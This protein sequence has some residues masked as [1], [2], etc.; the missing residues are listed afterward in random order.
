MQVAVKAPSFGERRK[1]Y[2]QDIAIATG[3]TY[4]AEEVGLSL[5]Q[6]S[7]P[8]LV[9]L[10]VGVV[11]IYYLLCFSTPYP[12]Q[13]PRNIAFQSLGKL[14]TMNGSLAANHKELGSGGGRAILAF[15]CE[16][17]VWQHKSGR[18]RLL[19]FIPPSRQVFF[20]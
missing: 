10:I 17:A 3:S 5:D 1:N 16:R 8:T 11:Y 18:S 4:I 2:L 19:A 20:R 13:M 6:V 7:R 12:L 9:L 14:R 15:T